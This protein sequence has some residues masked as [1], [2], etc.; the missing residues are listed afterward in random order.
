MKKKIIA[1]IVG[2]L[3][4]GAV[5]APAAL[6]DECD[7]PA[8][9]VAPSYDYGVTYPTYGTYYFRERLA[10]ERA[11]AIRRAEARRRWWYLHH[12]FE[13]YP[14]RPYVGGYYSYGY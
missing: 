3:A 9:Y 2:L 7:R 1:G 8:T 11:E 14:Y 4:L 6:A 12:R 13:R 5:A 10:R